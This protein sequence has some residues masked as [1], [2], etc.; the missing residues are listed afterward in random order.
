MFDK[1]K[2]FM[3]GIKRNQGGINFDEQPPP[4]SELLN[5]PYVSA[6]V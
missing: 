6:I 4:P 2:P 1:Q 5:A 3:R